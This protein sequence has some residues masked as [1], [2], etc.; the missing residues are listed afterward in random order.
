MSDKEKLILFPNLTNF[1]Q[2]VIFYI[3]EKGYMNPNVIKE[4]N[5][6]CDKTKDSIDL[7]NYDEDMNNLQKQLNYFIHVGLLKK[8]LL[9]TTNTTT[10]M[11]FPA[12]SLV[13]TEKGDLYYRQ[14]LEHKLDKLSDEKIIDTIKSSDAYNKSS[15]F[16]DEIISKLRN[17]LPSY[18]I[19]D[20]TTAMDKIIVLVDILKF[21]HSLI[22]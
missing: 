22:N 2:W 17:D 20:K 3:K 9:A 19:T 13:F 11:R 14:Q 10:N 21:L 16:Y 5:N 6:F 12:D 1:Q 7:N 15:N 8:L 18:I 4:I